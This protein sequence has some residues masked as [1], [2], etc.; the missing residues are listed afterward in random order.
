[1]KIRR[2]DENQMKKAIQRLLEDVLTGDNAERE[3]IINDEL[4]D[5]KNQV[6]KTIKYLYQEVTNENVPYGIKC[7]TV[8]MFNDLS[9]C[10]ELVIH[11]L[12]TINE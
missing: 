5:A 2:I 9:N 10:L 12:E 11:N 8:K 7:E 4:A 3:I 6:I 1:M